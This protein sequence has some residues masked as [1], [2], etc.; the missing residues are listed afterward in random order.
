MKLVLFLWSKDNVKHMLIKCFISF[1]NRSLITLWASG[2]FKLFLLLTTVYNV[3]PQFQDQSLTSST[4]SSW[5]VAAF[6][7]ESFWVPVSALFRTSLLFLCLWASFLTWPSAF[8]LL[9][10]LTGLVSHF[11]RVLPGRFG[12]GELW[13]VLT[14]WGWSEVTEA[15]GL[16][17]LLDTESESVEQSTNG[18]NLLDTGVASLHVAFLYNG[19]DQI[20][21]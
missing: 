15:G 10:R 18:K 7:S 5:G 3:S 8:P 17:S 20:E 6:S 1:W 21:W 4:V 13:V 16:A 12:P 11:L 9:R 14:E 2:L 19:I